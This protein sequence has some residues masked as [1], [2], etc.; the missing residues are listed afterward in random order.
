MCAEWSGECG[1]ELVCQYSSPFSDKGKCV[2]EEKF[3]S[4]DVGESCGHWEG[5]C[6]DSLKCQ[7]N[8][9]PWAFLCGAEKSGKIFRTFRF[10]QFK[11]ITA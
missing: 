2:T 9:D 3:K 6:K 10:K 4:R 11:N 7:V 1:E 5:Q 8:P